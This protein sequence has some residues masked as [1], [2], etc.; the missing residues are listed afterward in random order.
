[1]LLNRL[2]KAF[3]KKT[4]VYF[5]CMDKP[6]SDSISGF[7]EMQDMSPEEMNAFVDE[8]KIEVAKVY[9]KKYPYETK[10]DDL[11]KL[12]NT[13]RLISFSRVD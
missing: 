5:Y 11:Q 12:A 10:N 6:R 13:F 3:S 1:M 9:L 2:K 8:L 7:I 4:R